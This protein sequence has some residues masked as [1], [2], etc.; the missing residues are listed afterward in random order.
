MP[1]RSYPLSL[2]I[3]FEQLVLALYYRTMHERIREGRHLW[4]SQMGC[5]LF[6]HPQNADGKILAEGSSGWFVFPGPG[7]YPQD[8]AYFFHFIIH[9][10]YQALK[11]HSELDAAKFEE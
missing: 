2:A 8:E 1:T 9:M 4:D 7:G 6:N 3:L 10:I 5:H 11:K